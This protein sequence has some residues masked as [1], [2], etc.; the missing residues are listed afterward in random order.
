MFNELFI[1][2]VIFGSSLLSYRPC[3]SLYTMA[4]NFTQ[5]FSNACL[6]FPMAYLVII[7]FCHWK[8]IFELT[9][10]SKLSTNFCI[11]LSAQN[12]YIF[13]RNEVLSKSRFRA[14]HWLPI[15]R[16]IHSS[17]S[18]LHR[19]VYSLMIFLPIRLVVDFNFISVVS[20]ICSFISVYKFLTIKRRESSVIIQKFY[21]SLAQKIWRTYL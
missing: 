8:V 6:F 5:S 1:L 4:G 21:W 13:W 10:K 14:F 17:P 20:C 18:F 16:Q 9:Y 2:E 15:H 11:D 19:Q 3:E 12:V 7:D